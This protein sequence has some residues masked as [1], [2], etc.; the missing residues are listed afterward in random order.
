[1]VWQLDLEGLLDWQFELEEEDCFW[2]TRSES[3]KSEWE[4]AVWHKLRVA[5][6]RRNLY[7]YTNISICRNNNSLPTQYCIEYIFQCIF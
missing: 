1:M 7:K 4:L 6:Q 3:G 2:D 5:W